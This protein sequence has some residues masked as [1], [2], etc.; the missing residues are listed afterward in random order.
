MVTENTRGEGH[1]PISQFSPEY[2]GRQVHVQSDFKVPEFSHTFV[3]QSFV[4]VA[5]VVVVVVEVLVVN[6]AP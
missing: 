1:L 3:L 4:V 5:I 6:D 2:G